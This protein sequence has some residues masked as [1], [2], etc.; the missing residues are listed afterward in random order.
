MIECRLLTTATYADE[1]SAQLALLGA[2]AV[3]WSD[4]GEQP[5][6][7]PLPG[8]V[9]Y[10]DQ[11]ELVAYFEAIDQLSR[12][13]IFLQKRQAEGCLQRYHFAEVEQCDWVRVNQEQSVPI[14]FGQRLWICPSWH[15]PPEPNQV[16]VLFNAGVAF[17][18]GSHA[19]TAMC[20]EWL[21]KH[22][23]GSETIIDYGCGS[24][25]LA[26]AAL[27]LGAQSA[28]GVD[29]DPQA[30]EATRMNAAL[31]DFHA[32]KIQVY[33]PDQL[34]DLRADILL[35][36]ILAK[37]LISLSPLFAKLVKPNGQLVL[38]GLMQDQAQAVMRAYQDHFTDLRT[39]SRDEWI[40]LT[41]RRLT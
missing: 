19:T 3:T 24:G 21:D 27:K 31:N 32:D 2:A 6:Y 13:E 34:P 18:T 29:H 33:L 9:A 5:I 15:T 30:L 25:I 20:M 1:L 14:R 28:V 38:S 22:I 35:A 37:P 4:A 12:L 26:V 40:C 7:E 41:G 10:W 36:N 11:I 8:E 39:T 23:Q 16:N 17:G